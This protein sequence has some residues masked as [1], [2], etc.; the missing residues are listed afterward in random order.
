MIIRFVCLIFL[1]LNMFKQ[2]EIN[3]KLLRSIRIYFKGT[4]RFAKKECYDK[5][6]YKI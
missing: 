2:L 1:G 4:L 3:I 6:H 5:Y